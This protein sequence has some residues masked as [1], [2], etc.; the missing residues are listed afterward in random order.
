MVGLAGVGTGVGAGVG[1][2]VGTGVG[3]ELFLSPFVVG[4]LTPSASPD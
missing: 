2:G 1:A 4:T 3:P